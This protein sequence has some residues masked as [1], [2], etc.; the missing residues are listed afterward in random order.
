LTWTSSSHGIFVLFQRYFGTH[1]LHFFKI[2]T[3]HCDLILCKSKIYHVFNSWYVNY[4]NLNVRCR[5]F[6]IFYNGFCKHGGEVAFVWTWPS[7]WTACIRKCIS[8]T[9][10]W[11]F[12]HEN[13]LWEIVIQH[14]GMQHGPHLVEVAFIVG[15]W[16]CSYFLQ[17][18]FITFITFMHQDL[19]TYYTC[20]DVMFNIW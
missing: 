12:D 1:F 15:W 7:S 20:L 5:K 14:I 8:N 2:F 9:T 17:F 4:H 19:H 13:L 16:P 11:V 18:Y 10:K 3:C 6:N